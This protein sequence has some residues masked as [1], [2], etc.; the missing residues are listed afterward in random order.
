MITGKAGTGQNL[1]TRVS[2]SL[3]AALE[4]GK[5]WKSTQNTSLPPPQIR[6]RNLKVQGPAGM[7]WVHSRVSIGTPELSAA[8]CGGHRCFFH[9]Q[10]ILGVRGSPGAFS[11]FMSSTKP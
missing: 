6:W 4:T 11:V 1:G 3:V 8:F 5:E 10:C 2:Q 9:T 7:K